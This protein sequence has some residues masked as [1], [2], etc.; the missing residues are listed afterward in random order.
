MSIFTYSK[1]IYKGIGKVANMKNI[2][3][4]TD[5]TDHMKSKEDSKQKEATGLKK[6]NQKPKLFNC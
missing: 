2:N 4:M 5:H 3:F 1:K 6:N